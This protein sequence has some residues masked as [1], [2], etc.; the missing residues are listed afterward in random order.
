MV[1]TCVRDMHRE[2]KTQ[3]LAVKQI[4][5]DK[6]LPSAMPTYWA[7][8][9]NMNRHAPIS[10]SHGRGKN[11]LWKVHTYTQLCPVSQVCVF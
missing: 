9:I 6:L 2:Y 3:T 5:M 1:S 4:A 10:S 11:P 8:N 7:Q